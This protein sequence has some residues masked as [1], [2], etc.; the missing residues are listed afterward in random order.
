MKTPANDSLVT[1][2]RSKTN[3]PG[4]FI[5]SPPNEISSEENEEKLTNCSEKKII[6]ESKQE[7]HLVLQEISKKVSV[8]DDVKNERVFFTLE[9]EK[10]A[11]MSLVSGNTRTQSEM[12]HQVKFQEEWGEESNRTK[13]ALED[14]KEDSLGRWQ[15]E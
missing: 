5:D 15:K 4:L 3:G 14:W 7:I 1:L 13:S 11:K 6:T 8:I 9:E 10:S 2:P 12:S